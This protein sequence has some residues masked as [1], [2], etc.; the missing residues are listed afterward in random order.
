MTS[1][2]TPYAPPSW[3]IGLSTGT[4]VM[5]IT[6]ITPALPLI[7]A[8]MEVG[9]NTVQF[10]FTSY[11]IMLA[12]SQLVVG[13]FS[14]LIG[15]RPFILAGALLIAIGGGFTILADNITTLT[16]G[17][18]I[19]GL[20]AGACI[21]MA[22]A[23]I[24]D[25]FDRQQAARKMASVQS[26]QAI[27]P[28]IA[29][30]SGG[31]IVVQ[32]GWVGVMWMIFCAGVILTVSLPL[33]LRETFF[34]TK[35]T[36]NLK[37]IGTAYLHV[38]KIPVFL[39]FTVISSTQVGMFFAMNAFLPYRYAE[40]GI[41]PLEFG[42]WFGLT[43]VA[44][45]LGNLANRYFF[46]NLGIER[47]VLIGCVLCCFSLI[48]LFASQYIGITSVLGLALPCSLFGFSNGLTI[49][50]T[51]IGG[52]KSAGQYAGT[53]SG[54]IGALQMI[55]GSLLG[56]IIILLGGDSNIVLACTVVLLSG[57]LS[58][59]VAVMVYRINSNAETA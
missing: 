17:R 33:L 4:A 14:D 41:S 24:N 58:M 20:G 54:I 40:L 37:A 49:A 22:R 16:A 32:F 5:G 55:T 35:P 53:G 56:I 27:V 18:V 25:S 51:V 12:A 45:L 11:L 1:L 39:G 15:R 7:S 8:E 21:S 47:A 36:L 52:I 44:Y 43:P 3:L 50:N 42:F 38:L 9:A 46:V 48:L 10:L 23:M 57:I 31:A 34:D 28:I 13:P 19:Q 30:M 59:I 6:L 29:L 26:I 2:K